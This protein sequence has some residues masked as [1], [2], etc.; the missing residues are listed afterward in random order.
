MRVIRWLVS[1]AALMVL[2]GNSH[3]QLA[4][5][6]VSPDTTIAIGGEVLGRDE[7][8][9]D[10]LAGSVTFT[11]SGVALP[12]GAN[13]TA[14]E[15]LAGGGA[16]FS[17]DVT[18]A[19]PGGVVARTGDVA[20]QTVGNPTLA[21][22]GSAAGL[23]PG[24][25]VDAVTTIG[26]DLLLSFDT[27]VSLGGVVVADED[28]VRVPPGGAP[29]LFYDGSAQGIEGA[30][31]LDGADRLAD[32]RLLL[33][34]DGTGA[35]GGVAFADEDAVLFDP[36]GGAYALA[37]DGSVEYAAWVASDLDALD[38]PPDSDGDGISDGLDVCPF[39]DQTSSADAD[40]D[41][42]GDECECSDQ[43]GN[44]IVNVSDLVAI[45]AAI[46]NP[47]LATPLCDGNNDGLC[48]VV[49]IVAA[50]KEIFSKNSSTC[51]R[52]PI[53]GP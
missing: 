16:L 52:Q 5:L 53:P 2:A 10:D 47:R 48:N 28:L 26:S 24:A 1:P 4:S 8:G 40:S 13:L 37:Y 9:E 6:E 7:V 20:R 14:F 22:V 27:T 42:R 34:F 31:D 51:A 32:G 45:N 39:Y 29:S 19:L 3:A 38:S 49:D 46:F 15:R 23:P 21:F 12:L 17:A 11:G 41:G 35:A 30:L 25:Q 36:V 33:S 50:N 44:G 43:T 18:V